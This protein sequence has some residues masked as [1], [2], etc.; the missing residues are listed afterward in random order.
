MSISS[1]VFG[2]GV[3]TCAIDAKILIYLLL[4]IVNRRSTRQHF[5]FT[6]DG[7]WRAAGADIRLRLALLL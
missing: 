3:I 2:R 1:P 4:D 6:H 5:G 7:G